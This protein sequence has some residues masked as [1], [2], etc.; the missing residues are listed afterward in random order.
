MD[1]VGRAWY[2]T[3]HTNFAEVIKMGR[4]IGHQLT[5]V[6]RPWVVSALAVCIWLGP[7]GRALGDEGMW[8][9][10]ELPARVIEDMRDKGCRLGPGDVWNEDGTGIANAIVHLGATGAFVSPDGLILTNHHVAFG[11]V[12]RMSTPENNYI[13]H[14]FLARARADEVPALG[15]TAYVIDTCED[16]TPRILS[17]AKSS[18]TPLDR[19][20]AI[21]RRIKQVERAAEDRRKKQGMD[22]YCEVA[23]F[24]GARYI[25]YTFLK[26]RD[27]RVAYVPSRP[28]GEYGGDIDNWM[29]PRHAADFSFLRAYVAPDG[30]PAEFSK[31]NVPYRPGRYLTVAPGGIKDGEFTLIVGFPR[32]THRY[33][34]SYALAD[35]ETFEFPQDIRLSKQTV[36]ILEQAS[37]ED[38]AAAVR[39]AGKMKG[40]NNYIKKNTGVLEGFKRFGL[41]ARQADQERQWAR[42]L[43]SNQAAR[44]KYHSLLAAFKSLYEAKAR[45]AMKDLLLENATDTGLLGQAML[46]YRWS[47]EKARPDLERESRF[48]E[49]EV[50][51]LR[52]E[53]GIFQRGFDPA[54]DREILKMFFK[55][56]AGLPAGQRV[57]AI[58][59]ILAKILPGR[60]PSGEEPPLD[61]AI[62]KYLDGLYVGTRLDSE[63][64]RLEMFDLSHDALVERNESFIALAA[65]LYD[66]TLERLDR[67]KA[68]DGALDVLTPQWMEMVSRESGHVPY[69][70]ANSTMR[71]NYGVVMGYSPRDAVWYDPFTT[72]RGVIEKNTG[73]AP[74]NC[75]ASIVKLAAAK[76]YGP[77]RDTMLDDVPVDFLTT[78]D[79][80]N[81][82]SGSPVLNARGEIVGCLFDGNYEAV[83]GDFAF[84]QNLHRSIS[85]DIRY[86]LWVADYVDGAENILRELNVK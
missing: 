16:V 40:L 71:L 74:F 19:Y 80:T 36:S 76:T 13:E 47:L 81:G 12:Q 72:L 3:R 62:D 61:A 20:K 56:M 65:S 50:P 60:E 15:Y 32:V 75:P 37:R 42:R 7:A 2:H 86:V 52:D 82:N 18:M 45:Y 54:S 17:A 57:R 77:Y 69:P 68:L 51:D 27:I 59:A 38:L 22:A 33:L 46:I 43:D 67:R 23:G 29:W 24:A 21:D 6:A 8:L 26:I 70:D 85:V 10:H 49:R 5:A 79:S 31:A 25:L 58:D 48:M 83:S 30:R 35:Y 11:S 53:V 1:C 34:T 9:P 66:E 64:G 28:I 41:E 44:E 63:A 4:R 39:V 14:G 55:E 78:H 84:D 73:V